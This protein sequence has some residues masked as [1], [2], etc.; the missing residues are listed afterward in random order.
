MAVG[1][2]NPRPDEHGGFRAWHYP[3]RLVEAFNE[4]IA[5]AAVVLAGLGYALLRTFEGEDARD[6]DGREGAVVEVALQA[7][8]GVDQHRIADHEADA[9]AGHVVTL[10]Q[11]EELD[12]DIFGSGNFE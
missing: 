12:S 2:G 4:H 3:A 5:A 10:R 8:K 9:P 1:F 7:R 11:G 6:L